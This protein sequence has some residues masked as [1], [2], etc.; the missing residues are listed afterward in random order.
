MQGVSQNSSAYIRKLFFFNHGAGMV[1]GAC[2]PFIAYM[3]LGE[4][5]LTAQ[6][7]L[8][9]TFAGFCL[10]AVSF[11]FVRQTLKKQLKQQLFAL[12][13]LLGEDQAESAHQTVE[14]LLEAVDK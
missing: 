2:F 12:N 5:A 1:I 13:A 14:A 10:G 11:W 4:I 7:F 6:F 8:V 3:M 9:C